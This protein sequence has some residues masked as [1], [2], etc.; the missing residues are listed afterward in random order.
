ME[1]QLPTVQLCPPAV[2]A[3]PPNPS[4]AA[5][6]HI[7]KY[8]QTLTFDTRP[9]RSSPPHHE[10][11]GHP[12]VASSPRTPYLRTTPRPA[13]SGLV[14]VRHPP[15]LTAVRCWGA[16]MCTLF[17]IA[18]GPPTQNFLIC[19]CHPAPGRTRCSLTVLVALC[20]LCQ[21]R[22]NGS[23]ARM[24]RFGTHAEHRPPT[25]HASERRRFDGRRCSCPP[26]PPPTALPRS[27]PASAH[28]GE[29]IHAVL[30]HPGYVPEG[31]LLL[32]LGDLP[33]RTHAR[34]PHGRFNASPHTV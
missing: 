18:R 12:G 3:H 34:R 1:A 23:N 5:A 29:P 25:I 28:P 20:A 4:Q 24:L 22:R 11:S 14:G 30:S 6:E 13:S 19:A 33:P 8:C 27:L 10:R 26:P 15:P 16:T 31:P 32:G 2:K 7:F 21:G 9:P 17:L